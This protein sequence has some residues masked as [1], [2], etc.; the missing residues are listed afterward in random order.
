[1]HCLST[2]YKLNLI[3]T[4]EYEHYQSLQI[5]RGLTRRGDTYRYEGDQ[6][7]I[8]Y[9]DGKPYLKAGV[10]PVTQ[11]IERSEYRSWWEW[12]NR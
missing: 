2:I 1:M 12:L 6:S 11:P 9:H 4:G 3:A 10:Y 8:V 5:Y 7:A